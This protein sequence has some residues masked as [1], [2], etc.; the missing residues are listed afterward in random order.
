[1]TKIKLYCTKKNNR[2]KS[3]VMLINTENFNH[4]N[5]EK[6]IDDLFSFKIDYSELINLEF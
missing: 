5:F 2:I 3:E 4:W 6:I 1:M